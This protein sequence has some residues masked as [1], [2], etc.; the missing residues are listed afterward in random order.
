VWS[1]LFILIRLLALL[2]LGLA[3]CLSGCKKDKE[4]ALP[5]IKVGILHSQHGLLAETEKAIMNATL[6]AIQEINSQGGVL[7]RDI[8]PVLGDGRSS[9]SVFKKEAERLIQEEGVS[10]IFGGFTSDS[11]R[12]IKEV[13]EREASILFYPMQ[14]EGLEQSKNII[15]MGACPNQGAIPAISW[16]FKHLGRRFA[17]LGYH[18]FYSYALNAVIKDHIQALGGELVLESYFDRSN[19]DFS[20]LI[21]DLETQKVDVV[22]TSQGYYLSHIFFDTLSHAKPSI[23]D[24][25]IF[26]FGISSMHI[27]SFMEGKYVIWNYYDPVAPPVQ[28]LDFVKAYRGKF[29][30]DGTISDPMVSAYLG[31]YLWAKAVAQAEDASPN[32]VLG[33]LPAQSI[34]GPHGLVYI[35]PENNHAY[36]NVYI[37][38]ITEDGSAKVIW[39]S[40]VPVV[41]EPFPPFRT[42]DE[43]NALIQ[44]L[45]AL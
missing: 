41:P 20:K 38:R 19:P 13:V 18:S 27:S 40:K 5:P 37:S 12:A 21:E 4:I 14:Y 25:P 1:T 29:G 32:K 7:G 23:Q 35:S 8:L 28:G 22:L 3:L 45:P 36:R 9:P 16:A 2:S 34:E 33:Y 17:I 39:K 26:M 10:A 31:V 44:T 42:L 43:W 11:R 15:Y 6:L 30:S 24:I